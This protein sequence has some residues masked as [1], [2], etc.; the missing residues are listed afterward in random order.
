MEKWAHRSLDAAGDVNQATDLDSFI[1]DPTP[2]KHLIKAIRGFRAFV[3]RLSGG[4][5]SLDG[6][7]A[8]L[9]TCGADIQRDP[10]VRN[11]FDGFVAY[12]RKSVNEKGYVRSEDAKTRRRELRAEWKEL[13]DKDG[14]KGRSWKDDVA[15]LRDEFNSFQVAVRRDKELGAVRRAH[16]QLGTDLEESLITAGGVGLQNLMEKAPWFYQDI[17]NVYVPKVMAAIRDIPIP[18][19]VVLHCNAS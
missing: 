6:F 4:D 5:T 17:F 7:F 3:E 12:L 11:W 13:T 15:Q 10:D 9:R 16:T 18:R 2:E 1:D 19:Y 14:E 8:A